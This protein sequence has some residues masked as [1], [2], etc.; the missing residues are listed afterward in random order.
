MGVGRLLCS[1]CNEMAN[2]SGTTLVLFSGFVR[3]S[4]KVV[5]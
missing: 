3:E 4:T 1:F 2:V 5:N